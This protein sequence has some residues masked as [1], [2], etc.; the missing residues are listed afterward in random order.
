MLFVT[1]C[2]ACKSRMGFSINCENIIVIKDIHNI[3]P[4]CLKPRGKKCLSVFQ[5]PLFIITEALFDSLYNSYYKIMVKS[6]NAGLQ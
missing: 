1:Y 6:I 2:L 4:G 3:H 5:I